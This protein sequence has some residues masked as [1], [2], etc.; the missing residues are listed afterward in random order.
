MSRTPLI[1][2]A[3]PAGLTAALELARR[4]VTPR[5]YE[6]ADTVG[7]LARTP[8]FGGWRVDPGGHRFFTRSEEISDLWRSLLPADEWI[9]VQRSSA[10]LVDGHLVRYPLVGRDLLRQMGIRSGL[11]GLGS[12]AWSRLRRRVRLTDRLTNFRDWGTEEF[13]RYWYDMFFDGYVRKTWLTEPSELSSDW[14][15]QRIRPIGW[16]RREETAFTEQDVFRYPRRG[17]GQLWEAAAARLADAGVVTSLNSPV[18]TLHYDGNMWTLGLAD[19]RTATGDAVFS[20]MP[21]G[22]LVRALDPQPPKHIRS[23][24]A[25]LKH[26]SLITVAVALNT[27]HDI[28]YNWVYTPAPGVRAGRVQNYRRWSEGLAPDGWNGTFL[29]FEY[30]IGPGGD[31][32]NATDEDLT[33]LVGED[34]RILG[35]DPSTIEK[36]MFVR[37]RFAYPI[38]DPTRARGVVR[39][40][41]YLREH[42][43]SLHPMGRN[44][45]HRY[46]NQDHAMLSALHSVGRYFGEQVTDP[47]H[48]NTERAYH[49]M[50]LKP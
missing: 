17:P 44:G 28:P 18:E 7:G 41:D 19:G 26:R 50:G 20:S 11:H 10:M 14:A 34:L 31:L 25:S 2:G 35:L 16:H 32:W 43:P 27:P 3:G 47:W 9:A 6:A 23:V 8:G 42:H 46:D 36:V 5:I 21:L 13:G 12:L 49:E 22:L 30:F 48:V 39:I 1:I 37:S 29:G 38:H 24:A 33:E 15:L 45:M 40:R 4:G